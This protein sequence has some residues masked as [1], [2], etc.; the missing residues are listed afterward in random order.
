MLE[1]LRAPEP[2]VIGAAASTIVDPA[3][4]RELAASAFVVWLRADA[5]TLA[6]RLPQSPTRP[7]AGE[8]PVRLVAGQARE[9]DPLFAAAADLTVRTDDHEPAAIVTEIVAAREA[10]ERA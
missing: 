9:R 5:A 3:V 6:A 8:D 2:A 1:A 4:R 10:S 7:F